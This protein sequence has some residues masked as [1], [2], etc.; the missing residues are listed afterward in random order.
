MVTGTTV[1][2]LLVHHAG[3]IALGAKRMAFVVL[4]L[5][6]MGSIAYGFIALLWN[7][8]YVMAPIVLFLTL[9]WVAWMCGRE[10]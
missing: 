10:P 7:Y 8:P 6:L 3:R 5:L 2:D 1:K 4:V 9:T